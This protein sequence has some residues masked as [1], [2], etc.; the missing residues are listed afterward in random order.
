MRKEFLIRQEHRRAARRKE[1]EEKQFGVNTTTVLYGR[2]TKPSLHEGDFDTRQK[3]SLL[4]NLNYAKDFKHERENELKWLR[5]SKKLFRSWL[6]PLKRIFRNYSRDFM[7]QRTN[8]SRL[9]R[10]TVKTSARGRTRNTD[11][12]QHKAY[13]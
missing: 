3:N 10:L 2:T 1:K 9:K 5:Q 11:K 4:A 6:V 8:T 13:S 7:P 12:Q